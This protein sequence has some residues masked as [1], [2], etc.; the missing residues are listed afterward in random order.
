M[1]SGVVVDK[2]TKQMLIGAT[3]VI[4]GTTTGTVTNS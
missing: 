1:V 4:K 2:N 3:V